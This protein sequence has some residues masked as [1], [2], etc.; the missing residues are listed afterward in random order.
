M[1]LIALSFHTVQT[2]HRNVLLGSQDTSSSINVVSASTIPPQDSEPAQSYEST[3]PMEDPQPPKDSQLPEDIQSQGSLQSPEGPQFHDNHESFSDFLSLD[4]ADSYCARHR[5]ALYPH[6]DRRRKIFESFLVNSDIDWLEIHLGEHYDLVD[7]FVVV[8]MEKTFTGH[9]KPLHA[10]ENWDRFAPY[11]DKIIHLVLN[12]TGTDF[13]NAWDRESFSRNAFLDQVLFK[14]EGDAA[15]SQGDVILVSD[16][17]EITRP[18]AMMA[19]R[20]CE[21]SARLTLQSTAY[22]YSFQ[23]KH[24]EEDW[25]HPQATYYDGPNTIKPQD[26]RMGSRDQVLWFAAWHCSWCFAKLDSLVEKITSFSHTEYNKP[27]FKDRPS[28]LQRVRH[29]VYLFGIQGGSEF[30]RVDDNKDVPAFL[31]R[32]DNADKF[33]YVLDRDPIG[34]NFLDFD[35]AKDLQGNKKEEV[36]QEVLD[37]IHRDRKDR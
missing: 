18:G 19:M 31:L 8:E 12:E 27:E 6:R 35:E 16:V 7:T 3:Q 22:F 24:R 21:F 36:R 5:L 32:K 15:P 17:D 13:Q 9:P 4:E 25:F 1:L 2:Y 26:L 14:M 30:D 20:N 29:G 34:G 23:W 10:K 28:L 11:H 37:W 33:S